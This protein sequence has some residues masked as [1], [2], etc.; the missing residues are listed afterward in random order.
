[1]IEEARGLHVVEHV[2]TDGADPRTPVVVLVH[3]SLDRGTSF[4]RVVRRLP[5][6]HVVTYDRR[7]YQ[8]SRVPLAADG[9]PSPASDSGS[10]PRIDTQP[11]PTFDRHVTDLIEVVGRR[12][13]V[14]VGHSLGGG[15]A[16]G[17]AILAPETVFAVGAYEPPLPWM[18]WWPSGSR[19]ETSAED[20][21]S[22]AESFFRRVVS[23]EGWDR[24]TERAR[25]E[26][27]ADGPAL[28]AELAAI[29]RDRAPFDLTALAVP[30]VFGHGELS[31]PH[32]RRSIDALEELIPD[33]QIVEIPGAS[34]GAHLS[35]P[36]SFADFVRSV[37]A[38]ATEHEGGIPSYD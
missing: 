38:R 18:D 16:L 25:A 34:H 8:R 4:A 11:P 21:A 35:H 3:G 13:S 12:P 33:A 20:P 1:M 28:V 15:V 32:R 23:D 17:A 26:R 2:P 29:R 6:L 36:D 19:H 5:D 31:V 37:L 30:A 10:P 22:Y 7:G 24:L 27:R 14:V 9:R